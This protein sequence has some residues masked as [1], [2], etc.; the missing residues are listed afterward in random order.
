GFGEDPFISP[1]AAPFSAWAYARER[2][3]HLCQEEDRVSEQLRFTAWPDELMPVASVL[4]A[5]LARSDLD[6]TT[7]QAIHTLR[8]RVARFPDPTL[9]GRWWLRVDGPKRPGVAWE[10]FTLYV[11]PR[12]LEL[13]SS[14]GP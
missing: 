5:A 7:R 2:A 9:G 14:D 3:S 8:E 13:S 10:H 12:R 11:Y 4:D 1:S 6:A